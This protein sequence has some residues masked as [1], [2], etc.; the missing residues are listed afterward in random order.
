MV[1]LRRAEGVDPVVQLPV[2]L[3]SPDL[4]EQRF[5]LGMQVWWFEASPAVANW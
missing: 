2:G 3:A 4:I 1:G 5:E